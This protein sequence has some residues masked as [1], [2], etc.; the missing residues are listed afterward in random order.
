L[1]FIF[2]K[3]DV[4]ARGQWFKTMG[5]SRGQEEFYHVEEAVFLA[6]QALLRVLSHGA[7]HPSVVQL[8]LVIMHMH[9]R[10]G[11]N[12]W[13][14]HVMKMVV[15]MVMVQ[16]TV[17]FTDASGEGTGVELSLAQVFRLLS[18]GGVPL[19]HYITYAHLTRLGFILARSR[20]QPLPD[21]HA[22]PPRGTIAS[23]SSPSSVLCACV[24]A[25]RASSYA[26]SVCERGGRHRVCASSD[27]VTSAR[28]R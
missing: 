5:F 7:P 28:G 8:A 18:E 12:G 13:R 17:S 26:V 19:D 15:M 10:E 16:R 9:E 24:M 20:L 25:A 14:G 1:S 11:R 23:S 3:M 6:D 27:R 4:V 21:G 22:A 2:L